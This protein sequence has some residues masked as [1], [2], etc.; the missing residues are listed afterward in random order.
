MKK[1]F[2]MNIFQ[3][4]ILWD[5]SGLCLIKRGNKIEGAMWYGKFFKLPIFGKIACKDITNEV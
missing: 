4:Q 5:I 2:C 1:V 3:F